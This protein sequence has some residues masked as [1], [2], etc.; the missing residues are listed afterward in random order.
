MK[1]V[2][3]NGGLEVTLV[4]KARKCFHIVKTVKED[5]DNYKIMSANVNINSDKID[6]DE[7]DT[8]LYSMDNILGDSDAEEFAA[9]CY[10]YYGNKFWGGSI[11][12]FNAEET[13]KF[14]EDNLDE[15]QEGE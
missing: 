14:I 6:K 1:I 3:D 15:N 12:Y 7:V 10:E 4:E 5:E 9:A 11:G 8:F 2:V 13:K